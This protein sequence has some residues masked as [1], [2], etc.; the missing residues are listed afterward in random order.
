MALA[1]QRLE[2]SHNTA[3]LSNHHPQWANP[4][5]MIAPLADDQPLNLLT[6]VLARTPTQQQAFEQLLTEQVDP[7][8]SEFHHWLTPTEIGERFGTA[9]EQ[10][11]AISGWLADNGMNVVAVSPSRTFI[12]VKATAS[13]AGRA[14]QT[15]FNTY[16]VNGRQKVS[17]ASEPQVPV[18]FAPS[19]KS[20]RG[21]FT[22]ED[23]PSA[24]G[25]GAVS[26]PQGVLS[27]EV[28]PAPGG[29]FGGSHYVTPA[30]FLT[31]YDIP[32]T[33]LGQGVT[34]GIVGR[35]RTDFADFTNFQARTNTSFANPIEIVPTNFGGI[36]PG[37]AQ[38]APN[39]S[40]TYS[41]DQFEAELDVLRSASLAQQAKIDLVVSTQAGGGVYSAMEYLVEANAVQVISNS[42]GACEISDG[43]SVT[44]NWNTLAQNAAAQ[45]I[46]VFTIGGDA[47]AAGCDTY[48][49]TPPAHPLAI[50]PNAIAATPYAT[51]VGGTEFADSANPS[52][53]WNASNGPGYSSAK[54][55]IP[56]GAWNEPLNGKTTEAA[57]G[58]GGVSSVIATPSWQTGTGVPAARKGRYT[59]DISFT[60][61]G[62]DGY[63]SCFAAAGY[64]C[65]VNSQGNFTFEYMSGTSNTAPAMAGITA[66]LV[67]KQGGRMGNL[68]PQIYYLANDKPA[69][70]HD[71]T[72]ATSGVSNCTV[73]VPSM[74]NNSIPSPT[75]LTGGEAGYV[76]TV[77]YD[78]A[79]GLGSLDVKKFFADF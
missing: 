48:F 51:A 30:D 19:I 1:G 71:A 46:S 78:Q 44:E 13:Q 33:H 74:C 29:N 12:N 4:Q 42:F 50:S 77:G 20:I 28:A 65:V 76:L 56:E 55:Y 43:P 31:I 17:V 60:A 70:F 9:K 37:P 15:Q 69:A 39:Q 67:Q 53:Y 64:N 36:D 26:G 72:V 2:L 47:G 40:G 22:F 59:P 3:V 79:T 61:A 6:I 32:T 24:R 66:M 10:V 5:N 41:E 7:K 68:N 63:F 25:H 11:D 45:G 54:G 23:R 34:I 21:L 35:S 38:T 52:L 73:S 58:G 14:F 75:G 27:T 16:M 57:S 49:A 18:E 8:S 62:H